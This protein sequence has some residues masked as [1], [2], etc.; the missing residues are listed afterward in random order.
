MSLFSRMSYVNAGSCSFVL[1]IVHLWYTG[2]TSFF[3][4]ACC[5]LYTTLLRELTLLWRR[6]WLLLLLLLMLMHDVF[7]PHDLPLH[8]CTSFLY[9][10]LIKGWCVEARSHIGHNLRGRAGENW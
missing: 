1:D 10:V 6:L 4:H 7:T 2:Y 5:L 9:K 8:M 3:A